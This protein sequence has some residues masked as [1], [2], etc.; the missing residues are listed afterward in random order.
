MNKTATSVL[1]LKYE[2]AAA[3]KRAAVA[4][5]KLAKLGKKR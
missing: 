4:E 5:A 3:E 2:K 1:S